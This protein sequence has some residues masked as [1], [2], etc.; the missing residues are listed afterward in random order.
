MPRRNKKL[1]FPEGKSSLY[2]ESKDSELLTKF[3]E[4]LD[5][6]NHLRSIRVLVVVPRNNLYLE[7][8]VVDLRY[9]SLSCVE[10]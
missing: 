9:H 10:K 5:S 1:P 7:S 8:L 4:V 6:T 3:C 2:I